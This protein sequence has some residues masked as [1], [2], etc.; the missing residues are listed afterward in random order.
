M[1]SIAASIQEEDTGPQV[2]N[3]YAALK[4]LINKDAFS[5]I[6]L[7]ELNPLK[8]QLRAD[9]PSGF[10]KGAAVKLMVQFKLQSGSGDEGIVVERKADALNALLKKFIL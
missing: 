2:A 10:C 8:E 1:Y 7:S 3:L 5:F 4:F 9:A 6:K